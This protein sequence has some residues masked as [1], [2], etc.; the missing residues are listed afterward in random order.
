MQASEVLNLEDASR[1]ILDV[2]FFFPGS[3]ALT[4]MKNVCLY[5]A[6]FDQIC[7]CRYV[8]YVYANTV[9]MQVLFLFGMC[10][11]LELLTQSYKE[12]R[13]DKAV[14]PTC[15]ITL[16]PLSIFFLFH[17]MIVSTHY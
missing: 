16:T 17:N 10:L 11:C 2:F 9:W 13:K 5:T 8:L 6:C 14:P 15:T 4:A 1:D 12:Q 3:C 7:V